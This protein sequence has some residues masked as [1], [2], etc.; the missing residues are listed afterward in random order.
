MK[1]LGVAEG[2]GLEKRELRQ[3]YRRM[4]FNVLARNQDDHTKNIAF[5]MDKR[6]RWRLAPAYDVTYAYNPS[7][8]WTGQH[9]MSVNGK[10]DGFERAD[11]LAVAKRYR[12]GTRPAMVALLE[13]VDAAVGRW[14]EFA[15][16]AGVE[17]AREHVGPRASGSEDLEG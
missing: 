6:G 4:V 16:A 17:R 8:A 14:R 11:L 2:L 7:G 3:L 15:E 5:L 10:R 9:Q 13:E 12:L 1:A